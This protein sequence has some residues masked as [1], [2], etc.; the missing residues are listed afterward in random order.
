V[1]GPDDRQWHASELL[2]RVTDSDVSYVEFLDKYLIDH[3][4]GASSEVRRL[5]R[6]AWTKATSALG[7]RID[8]QQAISALL[9][10][11]NRPLSANE[12]RQRLIAIRGVND[13][14]QIHPTDLIVRLPDRRW[15]LNDRDI[16]LKRLDQT[17]FFNRLVT[18]L[19][20]RG[21]GIHIT[22]IE[23]VVRKEIGDVPRLAPET[24]FSLAINDERL[25]VTTGEY[26]FLAEW[27]DARR[28]TLMTAVL[29]AL[30]ASATPLSIDEIVGDVEA[31]T[32]RHCDK[33]AVLSCLQ[34]TDAV[35]DAATGGWLVTSNIPPTEIDQLEIEPVEHSGDCSTTSSTIGP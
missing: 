4:L 3:V 13:H 28:Q 2:S 11:A 7:T 27:S 24:I 32:R 26:L 23:D 29:E 6:M 9:Q 25:K 34:A 22:E 30:R 20:S 18:I 19:K 10:H 31:R 35:V 17:S 16:A 15:G 12:I 1:D 33:R 8:V 5:G 21:D 14:L